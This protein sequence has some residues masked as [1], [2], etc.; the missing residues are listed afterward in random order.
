MDRAGFS[1]FGVR[2]VNDLHTTC[3]QLF[4]LLEQLTIDWVN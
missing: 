1:Y 4:K 2:W 3:L